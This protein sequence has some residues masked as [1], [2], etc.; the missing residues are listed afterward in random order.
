M[1]IDNLKDLQALVKYCRKAG[2]ASIEVDGIKLAIGASPKKLAAE[3]SKEVNEKTYT[4]EE[5]LF[6][7]SAGIDG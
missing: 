5:M 2:I 3:E 7:S 4:D 6:W 1:K